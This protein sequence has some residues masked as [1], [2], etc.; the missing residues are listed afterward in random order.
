[1]SM[2][3]SLLNTNVQQA[4]TGMGKKSGPRSQQGQISQ[5]LGLPGKN[6]KLNVYVMGNHWGWTGRLSRSQNQCTANQL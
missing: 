1:M 6:L 3:W 2:S 5:G 4:G